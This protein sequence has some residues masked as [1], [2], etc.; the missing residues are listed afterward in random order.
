MRFAPQGLNTQ[1]Y[2]LKTTNLLPAVVSAC[3]TPEDS[4]PKYFV[5]LRSCPF[6][7]DLGRSGVSAVCDPQSPDNDPWGFCTPKDP[8]RS[9]THGIFILPDIL[10][11]PWPMGILYTSAPCTPSCPVWSMAHGNP[12]LPGILYGP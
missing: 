10:Y 3:Y 6:L 11:S 1:G 8:V 12:V 5:W 9:M 4:S 7:C 2:T